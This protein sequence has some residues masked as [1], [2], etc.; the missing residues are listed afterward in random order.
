MN[1]KTRDQHAQKDTWDLS[2]LYQSIDAWENEYKKLENDILAISAFQG[3]LAESAHQLFLATQCSLDLERR[4]EKLYT[5]AHLKSDEDTSLSENLGRLD[6][7]FNLY[8]RYAALS[9]YINPELLTIPEETLTLFLENAELKPFK[10]L[11]NNIIRYKPHTLSAS[12]ENLL[13]M[14]NEV[15][16]ACDKVFS[17]LNNADLDFGI[18]SHNGEEQAL[19]HS[20]FTM[21]LRST[22]RE[23]RKLAFNQYYSVYNA[24]KNT[25]SATL[26]GSIKRNVYQA[27]VRHFNS[28]IEGALFGDNVPVSVYDNLISTVS[29]FLAPLQKY[30]QIRKKLLKLDEQEILDTYVPI[31]PEVNV[32]H[33]FEEAVSLVLESVQPLGEEYQQIMNRGLTEQRWCDVY[34]NIG[35]R[36]GAY[37]S[38]CYD[39]PPYLLLNYKE[40]LLDDVFTL[41]HEA[42]HSM[43]S[44]FS[45]KSQP[46]QDH[47]Y[48]IFVAEVASTFNEQLLLAHLKKTYAN[49]KTML[50][51]LVNYQIDAIK[52]TL[53]RQ[54]MFAEFEQKIHA[55][56][57]SNEALT[58]DTFNAVY[59]PLLKKYFGEAVTI[60]ETNWLEC[61]RIPHFYNAFY[62]YKYATGL[63]AAI[64]LSDGVLKGSDENRSRYLNFLKSGR[65]KFPIELL[66]D[67]GV[68]LSTPQPISTALTT[69][70]KLV[71]ELEELL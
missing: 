39:S 43:H 70:A 35:K 17:Q 47:D 13:A 26:A 38:G 60:T 8:T 28:T 5:Y 44:F 9:S 19:T 58:P 37:S 31:A 52:A 16:G 30:Y 62:V 56:A 7:A 50:T 54:T 2:P 20:S 11:I 23:F 12:E 68:D 64:A 34:E 1:K 32:R 10:R 27:R 41:A 55:L 42:G 46:F 3:K 24:H 69:F 36:S 22:D 14:G 61:L 49:D 21:L 59:T 18:I 48:T 57:D 45:R 53:Y 25:I 29:S 33:T 66:K 65:T 51:Y 63:S 6:R 71:D 4:L 40:E 15:F 67:A